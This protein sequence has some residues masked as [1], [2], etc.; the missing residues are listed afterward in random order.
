MS[1]IVAIFIFVLTYVLIISEKV[2]RTVA[3][4]LG[5]MLI[6]AL[7]IVNQTAAIQ[8]V[9]WNTLGL[10][11]GMMIVVSITRRSGVFEYLGFKSLKLA[12]GHPLKIFLALAVITAVLSALLD[13]VTTVLLIV[14]ISISIA[15]TLQLNPVPFLIS[16]I[17]ASNIGGTATMIGDP[18]NIMIASQAHLG[19]LDFL[20]N[21]FPISVV[22]FVVTMV[23]LL[24]LYRSQLQVSSSLITTV[25]DEEF[26]HGIKDY[27]LLRKSAVVLGLIITAFI[28]HRYLQIESGTV[29]L[30]GASILML[31]TKE[32]PEDILL[33]VEWPT[34]IFFIG[35]FILVGGL[36]ATGVINRLATEVLRITGENMHVAVVVVLW[37]SALASAFMDNIPFVAAMI[38]LIHQMGS[39]GGFSAALLQPLWWALAL[40][41][42][43]GGNGTLVGASANVIV[44]GVAEKNG[45]PIGFMQF[46]KVAFPLMLV[47]IIMA[48]GY[49]LLIY[50]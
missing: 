6:I 38:P 25:L 37:L 24:F 15:E 12:K 33:A 5:G 49:L 7:G 43:L 22:I 50:R 32:E 3:A 1:A 41:A 8:Y 2:H 21:L 26:V 13:N 16:E 40:G 9:D 47:S 11:T 42:C 18:P 35:L 14:P 27:A 31:I 34:I 44:A 46:F 36:E 29:A 23:V 4:L 28:L 30:I 20:V 10:L 45:S 19:F 17:L 39:T 48:N